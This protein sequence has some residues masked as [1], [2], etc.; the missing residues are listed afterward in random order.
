VTLRPLRQLGR[1]FLPQQMQ[2]DN[3]DFDL[4]VALMKRELKRDSDCLDVGASEGQFLSEM[5]RVA[6]RGEHVAWEPVPEYAMKLRDNFPE[7][8]VHEAALCDRNGYGEFQVSLDDPRGSGLRARTTP[9]GDRYK[10]LIVR[11]ERLD[12]ALPPEVS[13]RF[14]KVSAEGAEELVLRGGMETIR[15]FRPTIVFEHDADSARLYDSSP[16]RLH[17]LLVEQ[18]GYGVSGLDGAG[19]FDVAELVR[20]A[21]AG[22]RR[23]FVARPV[24]S[25]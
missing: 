4:I 24:G 23:N 3:S 8:H 20:I 5:S 2:G 21:S 12:D 11:F 18:L 10:A 25:A 22:E 14:I 1:R 16:D 6:S 13:P 9:S 15:R 17:E 7:A 19:P